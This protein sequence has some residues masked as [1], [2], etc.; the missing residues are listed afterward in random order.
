MNKLLREWAKPIV[1]LF[2]VVLFALVLRL[3]HLNLLPVFADEAIYIRWSQ[4]MGAEPT[5]R[6]L[7]LSDGKQPLFMWV[8]MFLVHHFED[9]LFAGRLISVLSGI[10]T[11]LGI[12]AASFVL[13]RSKRIAL[14]GGLIWAISPFSFFFDRMALVDSMLTMWGVWTFFFA[15]LTAKT[16]RIDAAMM[17]GFCLGFAWLTKSPALFFVL[18]LPTTWLLSDFPK[19]PTKRVVHVL[20]LFLLFLISFT[21]GFAMYNILRLG[22]NFQM[23]GM[24]NLDYV[25]PI[26]HF[27]QSPL[28]PLK[29][30]FLRSIEYI[31][32]WGPSV[33][34]LLIGS[35]ILVNL[36]KN[37][38]TVLVLIAWSIGP[39]LVNSE[40]A[41]VLTAR[42]ILFTLPF[43]Y[44]L[45]AS[46]FNTV[47]FRRFVYLFF[48]LFAAH[49]LFTNYQLLFTPSVAAMPRSER[50]G[51]L[52]EW[53]S[54]IGIR[55]TADFLKA[56]A[57]KDP[58]QRIV[59]GTEGYFGTLPDGLQIYTQGISNI[60]VIGI[61]LN[62]HE[63][64]IQLVES[65]QSGHKTYLVANSSRMTFTK[66]LSE[67]G[68]KVVKEFPK[69]DRP[70]D[71]REYVQYGPHETFY[72]LEVLQH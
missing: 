54:G 2:A 62:I 41:K 14:C 39:M 56:E 11:L 18:L 70:I 60:L 69:A 57:V 21:L 49:A 25:W 38:K 23:I 22:P 53:T 9:P 61:G 1:I 59:V 7:P 16:R 58:S 52:E 30:H 36:R 46:S 68:L 3:I 72:L 8:L 24:R 31:W 33:I 65:V 55:E 13:F 67:Y 66:D 10:C 44:I 42:Y 5:L 28:D 34:Y 64:P 35:G 51:Y 29:P 17:T 71:S 19:N 45:A 26:T 12:V 43:L 32:I 6:F 4:I 63:V 50:S 47:K 37:W 40:F 15:V 27:L 48:V 20:T